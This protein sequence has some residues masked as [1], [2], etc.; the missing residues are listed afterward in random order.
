[1]Q[2]HQYLGSVLTSATESVDGRSLIPVQM[3]PKCKPRAA[4]TSAVAHLQRR[5]AS[6]RSSHMQTPAVAGGSMLLTGSGS[7]QRLTKL[8]LIAD[9][10]VGSVVAICRQ[11]DQT[12]T[13]PGHSVLCRSARCRRPIQSVYVSLARVPK[14]PN[15]ERPVAIVF[16]TAS[17]SH[18]IFRVLGT[19]EA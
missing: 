7:T 15:T 14:S 4:G 1:M 16:L 12:V 13:Q 10:P 3:P 8:L 5:R 11:Q 19:P 2:W 9:V 6:M 18:I 17:Q